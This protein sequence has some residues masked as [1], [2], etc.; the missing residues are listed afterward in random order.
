M[1]KNFSLHI[2]DTSTIVYPNQTRS[3]RGGGGA[4]GLGVVADKLF[5]MIQFFTLIWLYCLHLSREGGR[6]GDCHCF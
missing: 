4:V 3:W 2:D 6:G 5:I 1:Q